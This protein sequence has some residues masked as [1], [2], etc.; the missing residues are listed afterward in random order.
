M[1]DYISREDAIMVAGDMLNSLTGISCKDGENTAREYFKSIPSTDIREN[2]KGH[3]ELKT[4][5]LYGLADKV[6][7]WANYCSVCG[8]H[9]GTPYNF[10]PNCGAEMENSLAMNK[11]NKGKVGMFR[12]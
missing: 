10:C 5:D 6:T 3:W 2:V 9:Y 1:K 7:A 8:Y 4:S 12:T 11:K